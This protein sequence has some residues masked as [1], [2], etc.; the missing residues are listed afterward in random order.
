[1]TLG[2]RI[3]A[4]RERLLP[5]PTQAKVAEQLKITDQAVSQWERDKTIPELERIPKLAR[6]LKVPVAWLL[7]GEGEPPGPEDVQVLVETLSPAERGLLSAT[8]HAL[9]AQRGRAA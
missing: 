5:K 4:A 2:K 8:I 9:R 3:K 6:E 7:E 1:M